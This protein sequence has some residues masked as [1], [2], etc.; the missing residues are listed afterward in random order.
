MPSRRVQ[1][2]Q[3]QANL[4]EARADLAAARAAGD[5]ARVALLEALVASGGSLL[6]YRPDRG[7]YGVLLGRLELASHVAVVVPGVGDATNLCDQWLPSAVHLFEAADSTSVILWKAYDNPP[8]LTMAAVESVGCDTHLTSAAGELTEFVRSLSL[9]PEQTLTVV[10]HSFGS[11][12]TGVALADF[13]LQC[14]DVVVAGSPGM[15]VDALRQ[16][17]LGESH[18]FSE[19][20]PGDVIAGLGIF[21]AEPTSPTFGG[22]RMRTNGP[23]FVEVE[24]HSNYFV[25]GSEALENIVDVVTGQYG[26]VVPQHSSLAETAGGLV[27]WALRIPMF[28][29]GRVARRYRGPGFRLLVN[30]GHLADI[31][32]S[33]TGNAVSEGID[34]GTRVV[35]WVERQVP[36]RAT[37]PSG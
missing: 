16:L 17:H 21:G 6:I 27:A 29:V 13:G 19:Q 9:R 11:T 3:S 28:P 36:G 4:A 34:I 5:A 23:G 7:H 37:P 18:F 12:V 24:S 31:G 25:P 1:E 2:D 10:A 14:T 20:A 22:T 32:A 8:D 26:L 35:A 15:T 30:A 33:Q